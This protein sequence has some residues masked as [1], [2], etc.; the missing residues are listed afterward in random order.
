M[1][2]LFAPMP[3]T[4]RTEAM[5]RALPIPA[6]PSPL[7]KILAPLAFRILAL[8]LVKSW[9]L[10]NDRAFS[11]TWLTRNMIPL[12]LRELVTSRVDP[13]SAT[14]PFELAA[15]YIQLLGCFGTEGCRL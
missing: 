8:S 14:A 4:P 6:S 12:V 10:P 2:C 15:R 5:T 9:H 11:L 7:C 3:S 13:K 1:F